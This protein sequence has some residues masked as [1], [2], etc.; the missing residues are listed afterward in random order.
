MN[1][2]GQVG[3]RQ[4]DKYH[5]KDGRWLIVAK[6]ANFFSVFSEISISRYVT[7]ND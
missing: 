5:Y 4:M 2:V 3:Q 7:L 6:M 1:V